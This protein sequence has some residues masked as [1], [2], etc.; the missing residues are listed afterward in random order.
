MCRV[1]RY[2]RQNHQTFNPYKPM[3]EMN[4]V[5]PPKGVPSNV[6]PTD[7][8]IAARAFDLWKAEGSPHGRM[9]H[10]VRAELE[11]LQNAARR[12]AKESEDSASLN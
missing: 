8:E 11:L 2:V 4:T 7:E 10:W 5:N 3:M 1:F 12:A 9:E 6:Y